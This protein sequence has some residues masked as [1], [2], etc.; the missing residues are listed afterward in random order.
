MFHSKFLARFFSFVFA[1]TIQYA[2][3]HLRQHIEQTCG[4]VFIGVRHACWAS[5]S[6]NPASEGAEHEED[7]DRPSI[8]QAC[9]M[10]A[11]FSQWS[12][13]RG[14]QM[15]IWNVGGLECDEAVRGHPL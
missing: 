4:R 8:R 12:P 14:D 3:T 10:P 6:P 1:R 9:T 15:E 5:V 2:Y 11:S 7:K 13:T